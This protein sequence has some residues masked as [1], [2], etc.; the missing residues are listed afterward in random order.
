MRGILL[1]CWALAYLGH[2]WFWI[3]KQNQRPA[4]A[5]LLAASVMVTVLFAGAVC[6]VLLP[7][8]VLLWL[9]GWL[10]FGWMLLRRSKALFSVDLLLF[11][12]GCVGLALRYRHSFLV[13]Y[14]DFSHWGM[15]VKHL[16]ASNRLPGN[17]DALITFQSYPPG[18]ALWIYGMCRLTGG[19]EGMMLTAQAVFML[20][21]WLPLL[22]LAKGKGALVKK[23][24]CAVMAVVGLS[25][26][27][28]SAS[29][30]VDN[31]VAALAVGGLCMV[32]VH[33]AQGGQTPML[34]GAVLAVSALI[35]DSGLFFVL[36]L[37]AIYAVVCL[38]NAKTRRI[39]R[40]AAAILPACAA[41]AVWYAHIK[42]AF[43]SAGTTRHA[44]TLDN[45]RVMGAD[46]SYQDIFR[47]GVQVFK[48]AASLHNLAI[49]ALLAMG[50][51]AAGVFVMRR[52]QKGVWKVGAEGA[53]LAAG[54]VV[55]AAW[56][57]M[58]WVTYVFSMELEGAKN[59]VAFERYNS[60][61]ALFLLGMLA[62][63]ALS[64]AGSGTCGYPAAVV[65]MCLPLLTGAWTNG[66]ER[67]LHETY[68]VPLRTNLEQAAV[69]RPLQSGERAAVVID[70]DENS[71]FAGYMAR[72]RLQSENVEICYPDE[73]VWNTADT[74]YYW[75][76]EMQPK[77]VAGV[78]IVQPDM[79]G[80]Q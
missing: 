62:A 64:C 70:H 26:L 5:P 61:C 19:S 58:L 27:Q 13:Q 79:R 15:I 56:L 39:G 2:I 25:L 76:S 11:A 31:L 28:G 32:A 67:L 45:M 17:G 57:V 6:R 33:A 42:L 37:A 73:V 20:A 8:A 7:A 12:A 16:L 38:R 29:L 52:M 46:K 9:S 66:A 3:E 49:Q 63:W 68:H 60:T 75:L 59:L 53:V 74:I 43:A 30:M 80:A 77:P 50:I 55:Y 4:I 71:L 1:L 72:Y 14:D 78:E 18:A 35:K 40:L 24:A 65:C 23:A 47:I 10:L 21:G 48:Q 22:A 51:F 36:V 69:Q 44:L 54:V 34:T 41:R